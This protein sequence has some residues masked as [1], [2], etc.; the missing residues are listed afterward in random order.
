MNIK[1]DW[2]K[3]KIKTLITSK[4]IYIISM[5]FSF[6]I[7]AI[8]LNNIIICYIAFGLTANMK[9][10]NSTPTCIL[11][12][13]ISFIMFRYFDRKYTVYINKTLDS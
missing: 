2:I 10:A 7:C 8:S 5:L 1:R 9:Y 4:Y 3:K 13:I 6:W 11:L 12:M